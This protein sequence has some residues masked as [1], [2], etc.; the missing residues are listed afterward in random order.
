MANSRPFWFLDAQT[1]IHRCWSSLASLR[2]AVQ[3]M[4]SICHRLK[5]QSSLC[6]CINQ[7]GLKLIMLSCSTFRIPRLVFRIRLLTIPCLN[8]F[9]L[10]VTNILMRK[11]A[12]CSMS[13]WRALEGGYLFLLTKTSLLNLWKNSSRRILCSSYRQVQT[14]PRR[15][16][17]VHAVKP[18]TSRFGKTRAVIVTLSA[19]Q[20]I[21]DVILRSRILQ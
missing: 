8:W 13:L 2:L 20:I 11:N 4:S 15:R 14:P 1:M 12:D 17:L 10:L 16:Y 19:A 6:L 5:R 7:R 9:W 21:R 3:A 18:G